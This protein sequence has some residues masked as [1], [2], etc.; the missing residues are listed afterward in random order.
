MGK[1]V[2]MISLDTFI[3][4]E[5]L[6]LALCPVMKHVYEWLTLTLVFTKDRCVSPGASKDRSDDSAD[7]KTLSFRRTV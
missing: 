1:P 4:R 5:S 3:G 2:P 6:D 7:P